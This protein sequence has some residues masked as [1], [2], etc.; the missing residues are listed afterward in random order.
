MD[1]LTILSLTVSSIGA[2][3]GIFA[4]IASLMLFKASSDANHSLF[5]SSHQTSLSILKFLGDIKASAG[6]TATSQTGTIDRLVTAI[7]AST[8]TNAAAEQ[9]RMLLE[10]DRVIELQAAD[11]AA[12]Q[13]ATLRNALTEMIASSFAQL[14][15]KLAYI[16]QRASDQ[17]AESGSPK[18]GISSPALHRVICWMAANEANFKF[19]GVKFLRDRIFHSD[20]AAQFA[21]QDA[22]D[23]EMLTLD[24]VENPKNPTWK[25][26][27]CALNRKNPDTQEI[28]ASCPTPDEN[29]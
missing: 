24:K 15:T 23:T 27:T 4:L 1:P 19:F 20:P 18:T 2:M 16:P 7:T 5:Q 3:V 26:T 10:V 25:T 22:I 28:L 9:S 29:A 8:Q 12:D 13:K 21:L 6:Q 17:L 11:L 14:S